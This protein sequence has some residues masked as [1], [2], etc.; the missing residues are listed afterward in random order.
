MHSRRPGKKGFL[1]YSV[2]LTKRIYSS[3]N[4]PSFSWNSD[5]EKSLSSRWSPYLSSISFVASHLTNASS[6]RAVPTA[7]LLLEIISGYT[8]PL[9]CIPCAI[10][11]SRC[12]FTYWKCFKSI[13]YFSRP[14]TFS[15]NSASVIF[16]ISNHLLS[17]LK[18]SKFSGS[19]KSEYLQ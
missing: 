7:L 6:F 14:F 13:L 16:P 15:S 9:L 11:F 8:E 12:C 1:K 5:Y 19:S 17:W 10:H 2:S 3:V 4:G 18:S